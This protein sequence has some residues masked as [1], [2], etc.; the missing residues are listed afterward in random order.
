MSPCAS[1]CCDKSQDRKQSGEGRLHWPHTPPPQS[2]TEGSQARNSRQE[3]TQRLR[4][5]ATAY[6]LVLT[7]RPACFSYN[8]G[9]HLPRGST[10]QSG[11]D[12][13]ISVTSQEN[14]L[15]ARPQANLMEVFPQDAPS[16]QKSLACL[17]SAKCNPES[18][19]NATQPQGRSLRSVA[20]DNAW[21]KVNFDSETK[22]GQGSKLL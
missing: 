19:A 12:P 7:A 4:R 2:Y 1:Y 21:E 14:T 11:L 20:S 3:L 10:A 18:V 9:P 15:Q 17:K 5:T 6:W 13:F 8:T 16:P 22:G